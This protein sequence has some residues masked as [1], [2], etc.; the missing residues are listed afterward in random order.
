MA[1]V[2]IVIPFFQREAGILSGAIRSV[3]D[4]SYPDWRLVIVDDGSPS[5]VD[6]D[7]ERF[8][9]DERTRV[10]VVRKANGGVSSARNAGLDAVSQDARFVAFL[11]SDDAWD[12]HH[13]DRAVA[14]LSTDGV[15][16]FWG[17]VSGDHFDEDYALA[18]AMVEP[19]NQAPLEGVEDG[20]RI[21]RF[22]AVLCGP[23][24]RHMH[25]SCL[26]IAA[27]V[28]RQTRFRKGMNLGED[29]AFLIDA[30]AHV[31]AAAASDAPA[32]ARGTGDNL[33]HGMAFEDVRL[34]REK[35]ITM[36]L[37]KDLKRN[38]ALTDHERALIDARL[39]KRRIQFYWNQV[40]RLKKHKR[41][42]W[43]LWRGWLG[44]DPALLATALRIAMKREPNPAR[45]VIPLEEA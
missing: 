27:N 12:P 3:L 38:P 14:A 13:L 30:A 42:D 11:D 41:L 19:H 26:V 31:R 20:F 18:S 39:E 1:A 5:P 16:M 7:L 28:A 4:Q 35:L 10:Q 34:A 24:W 17:A 32:M 9:D 15:D 45:Y 2:D 36:G 6:R 44:R 25:L 23:W 22:S 33:W 37:Y 8:T 29:F 40:E 43:S 21:D